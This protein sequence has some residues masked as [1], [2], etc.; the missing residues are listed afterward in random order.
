M[1]VK[2]ANEKYTSEV[3]HSFASRCEATLAKCRGKSDLGGPAGN[4]RT[5][6]CVTIPARRRD[7]EPQGQIAGPGAGGALPQ[8][9]LAADGGDVRGVDQTLH[10]LP[11]AMVALGQI[12]T[13]DNGRPLSTVE[14]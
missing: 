11:S 10:L 6:N 3:T 8:A 1:R 9:L 12:S 13:V 2:S 5:G 4:Y 7:P 14:I